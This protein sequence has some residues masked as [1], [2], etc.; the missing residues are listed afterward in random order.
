MYTCILQ[1]LHFY[2]MASSSLLPACVNFSACRGCSSSTCTVLCGVRSMLFINY[3]WKTVN[4][5]L[6]VK[7][8]W[9]IFIVALYRFVAWN[10]P[11]HSLIVFICSTTLSWTKLLAFVPEDKILMAGNSCWKSFVCFMVISVIIYWLAHWVKTSV[12]IVNSL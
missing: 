9:C 8:F 5:P 10:I 2:C 7:Y 6:K 4:K 1:S 3:L 12:N 11:L